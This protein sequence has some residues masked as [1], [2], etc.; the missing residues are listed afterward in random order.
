MMSKV[1][2][3]GF[4]YGLILVWIVLWLVGKHINLVE[5]LAG[6]GLNLLENEYYRFGTALLLH[7]D[8]LH[9]LGNALALYWVGVYLEPQ[10]SVL[11]LGLFTLLCAMAAQIIF[12]CFYRNGESFGGSP[13]I[14]VLIGLIVILNVT[15]KAELKYEIGTWYGNWVLG[16]AVLSNIPILGND[17][18]VLV[19][20]GISLVFGMVFG[21]IAIGLQFF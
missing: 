6:R 4:S 7:K 20:H 14:F 17:L 3:H 16:Y 10:V 13:V 12:L 1:A 11:K 8:V 9:L 18:S 21:G 2:Q 19:I 15:G 5:P